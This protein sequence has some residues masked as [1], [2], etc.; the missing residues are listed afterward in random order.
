MLKL[1]KHVGG[2]GGVGGYIGRVIETKQK[3]Q[4]CGLPMP[5]FTRARKRAG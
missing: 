1:L 3:R 5:I 4:L 2:G